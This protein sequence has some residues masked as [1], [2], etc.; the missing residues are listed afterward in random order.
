V[1]LT[2]VQLRTF[3][4]DIHHLRLGDNDLRALEIELLNRPDAGK[5]IPGTGGL[6]KMR[7]SPPSWARGKRG[8]TRV[9]Y[10][11]FPDVAA[12]YLFTIYTKN[13]MDNLSPADK[14]YFRNVLQQYTRWLKE[15]QGVLP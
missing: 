9:C 2:F 11:W 8:A 1:R 14:K 12:I 3:S 15:H 5:T 10:A 6:R 13:E 4:A 7:F